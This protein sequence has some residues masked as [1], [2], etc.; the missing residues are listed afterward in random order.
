MSGNSLHSLS[1][2]NAWFQAS[3]LHW[4]AHHLEVVGCQFLENEAASESQGH[5]PQ[6]A[7]RLTYYATRLA[8]TPVENMKSHYVRSLFRGTGVLE[9][10]LVTATFH[11]GGRLV[12][13]PHCSAF[14][15]AGHIAVPHPEP[16]VG[17]YS[18]S[19]DKDRKARFTA[20]AGPPGTVNLPMEEIYDRRL[21]RVTPQDWTRDPYLVCIMLSLAQVQERT[22]NNGRP[23]LYVVR[24][25]VTHKDEQENAYVYKADFPSQLLECLKFPSRPM[26]DFVFPSIT[27]AKVA[28]E[29]Y[30]T[31]GGRAAEALIGA[32]YFS[33]TT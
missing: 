21:A 26:D 12:H 14:R 25:L 16:I 8:T 29:P 20:R 33:S 18:Y 11:Y 19:A 15:I 10:V 28:F 13:V 30:E 23:R 7:G 27:V 22:D 6:Q 24:L 5:Y 31:F 9:F 2:K 3:P 32:Q 4:T 17:Y 1:V